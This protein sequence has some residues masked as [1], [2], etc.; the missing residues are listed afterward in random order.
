MTEM[1][2]LKKIVKLIRNGM[3]AKQMDVQ[4]DGMYPI[5]R[6]ETI[7]SAKIDFSRVKY[8]YVTDAQKEKYALKQGDILF[9]HINSPKHIGKTALFQSNQT[10][11]HGI[12]L[13]LIRAD[14]KKCYPKYLDYYFK[15]YDVR[16]H[17]RARCKKAVNQASLNQSDVLRLQIPLPP[18]AEQKRIAE[19][20]AKADRLRQLRKYA[21]QL[22]E[23]YL[24]SVFLEMFG[25]PATN[26]MG[27]EK[28]PLKKYVKV[29]G[30]FSFKSGDFG[31]SGVKVVKIT[32]VHYDLLTWDEMIFLPDDYLKKHSEFSLQENDI[33]MALTRPIIKSL[34][35]VK[36]CR[37]RK[38]DLPALLNQRVGRL[39]IKNDKKINYQYLL[40]L[41]Y[42]PYFKTRVEDY[43][44]ES[45]QPNISIN[46]VGEI[47]ILVPPL[48]EQ[49]RFAEIVARYEGL[50][51]QA[52]E[53][54]RQAEGLFQSLLNESFGG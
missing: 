28:V 8:T 24:Q 35:S 5:S 7:S 51:S 54:A 17:F 19:R 11:I 9:S 22:G 44:S 30:G 31:V 6:I 4:A 43:L 13:L 42:L 48:A 53:A 33:V 23:S 25:N 34:N 47:E 3:N 40:Q 12:N 32:N 52:R 37:V 16:A 36:I 26:P 39:I 10:L 45:L 2:S 18:L 49:E 41:C 27:W 46:Q 21:S 50:R 14:Q 20:L 1:V 29:Q 38:S 15:S